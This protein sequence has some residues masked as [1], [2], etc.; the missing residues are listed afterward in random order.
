MIC[1][2]CSYAADVKV[3]MLKPDD[4]RIKAL[5]A[6][7]VFPKSCC[8]Q[9]REGVNVVESRDKSQEGR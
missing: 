1:E 6:M 4:Q 3:R 8:C 2:A 9:H 7:C 5:H